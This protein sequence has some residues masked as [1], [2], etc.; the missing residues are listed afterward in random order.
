MIFAIVANLLLTSCATFSMGK[1][2]ACESI[3]LPPKPIVENCIASNNGTCIVCNSVGCF[4]VEVVNKVCR[5]AKQDSELFNWI[6]HAI[7]AVGQ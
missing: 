1:P 4:P 2:C 3:V 5:E 7:E 6:D